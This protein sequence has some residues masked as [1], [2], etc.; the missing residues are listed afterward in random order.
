MGRRPNLMILGVDCEFEL[1]WPSVE[2]QPDAP[3]RVFPFRRKDLRRPSLARRVGMEGPRMCQAT[4]M[5]I[6]LS[7]DDANHRRFLRSE[8]PERVGRSL[9]EVLTGIPWHAAKLALTVL[10]GWWKRR[11]F[12]CAAVRKRAAPPRTI[13]RDHAREGVGSNGEPPTSGRSRRAGIT[14]ARSAAFER[15]SVGLTAEVGAGGTPLAGSA[16]PNHVLTHV[17][18]LRVPRRFKFMGAAIVRVNKTGMT[19]NPTQPQLF[20][21]PG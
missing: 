8:C 3:A 7:W 6:R 17:V 13:G 2:Y 5:A 20:I 19:S 9:A 12:C 15:S 16:R 18:T 14:P 4:Q 10:W 1:A 21:I 11:R